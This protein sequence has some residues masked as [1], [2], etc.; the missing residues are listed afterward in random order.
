MLLDGD[1]LPVSAPE[2]D[3]GVEHPPMAAATYPRLAWRM[4]GLLVTPSLL[5]DALMPGFIAPERRSRANAALRS[6][7][8]ERGASLV[9]KGIGHPEKEKGRRVRRPFSPLW[10]LRC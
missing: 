4:S 10:I 8:C 9:G 5:A 7:H 3:I 1:R 6:M 2:P